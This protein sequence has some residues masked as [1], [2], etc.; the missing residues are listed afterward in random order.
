MDSADANRLKLIEAIYAAALEPATWSVVLQ[1]I[2]AYFDGA[3][4]ALGVLGAGQRSELVHCEGVIGDPDMQA[5][6]RAYYGQL[7][8]WPR[9]RARRP[10]GEVALSSQVYDIDYARNSAF[11]NE[12]FIPAGLVD[13]MGTALLR[14]EQN[15]ALLGIQRSARRG[16]FTR[17]DVRVF[18]GF[19]PHL[20]TALRVQ[21]SL[22]GLKRSDGLTELLL[23][24][25]STGVMAVSPAGM[26]VYAN[27]AADRMLARGDGLALDRRV[28]T[29]PDHRAHERLTRLLAE[30]LAPQP[31]PGGIVRV[32]RA[33]AASAPAAASAYAVL[34]A[35]LRR[36]LGS[37]ALPW[38]FDG[39]IVLV[40]DEERALQTLPDQLRALYGLSIEQARLLQA[41]LDGATVLEHAE[42]AGVRPTTVRFHLRHVLQKTGTESQSQLMRK[43]V[44]DLAGLP[45]LR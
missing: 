45:L 26:V 7:D 40:R 43:V 4:A 9:E 41:L 6:Y 33:G 38:P 44:G 22:G 8:P 19:V 35:P 10:V 1:K 39:A 21:R 18:A 12:Y 30:V 37:E 3:S 27:A 14:D 31:G 17:A 25:L 13:S 29:T 11:V 23:D 16:T 36:D 24:R 2:T 15:S 34:V 20:A 42:R 28:L 32:A 5:R